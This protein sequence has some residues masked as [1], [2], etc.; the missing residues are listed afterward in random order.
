MHR[1]RRCRALEAHGN[2][3]VN[4]MLPMSPQRCRETDIHS[5]VYAGRP[6]LKHRRYLITGFTLRVS[7]PA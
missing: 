5:H 6:R 7:R 2:A 1:S 4:Y 3:I